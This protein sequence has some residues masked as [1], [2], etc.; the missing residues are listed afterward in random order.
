MFVS[1]A[2]K[3]KYNVEK[4][5]FLD[6][7]VDALP[8]DDYDRFARFLPVAIVASPIAV[9]VTNVT[10]VE[11]NAWL[12]L[13]P[14][15][16]IMGLCVLFASLAANAGKRVEQRLWQDWDGPPTTRYL[17]HRNR[18]FNGHARLRL[19][20]HMNSLSFSVP[21]LEDE[22]AD[23]DSADEKYEA[24]VI[25][26]RSR[27]RDRHRFPLVRTYLKQYGFS[28]N[29]YAIRRIGIV[30]AVATGVFGVVYTLGNPFETTKILALSPIW[31]FSA[32]MAYTL[33][34]HV[35]AE[36]VKTSAERY[37]DFL[38]EAAKELE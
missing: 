1:K 12:M 36:A 15:P 31:V 34:F 37:A 11:V 26:I 2:Q 18:E 4:T 6:R 25:E 24:Y 16:V 13:I 14:V 7:I 3:M 23:P 27:S 8:G 22:K 35:N 9:C 30:I 20:E 17:R 21:A 38:F 33:A 28:R 32:V 10:G 19:H 5:D 29:L